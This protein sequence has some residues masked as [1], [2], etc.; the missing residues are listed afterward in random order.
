VYLFSIFIEGESTKCLKITKYSDKSQK[1]AAFFRNPY[2]ALPSTV[3][4]LRVD[5][6]SEFDNKEELKDNLER[7]AQEYLKSIKEAKANQSNLYI[8]RSEDMMSDPVGIIK[9]IALFF[10]LDIKDNVPITNDEVL[11]QIEN[12][13][14]KTEKTRVDKNGQAIIETL[15]SGHDGHMPRQKIAQRILL[16]NLIQEMDS[17]IITECYNEYMSIKPTNA[18]EGQRWGS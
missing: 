5:W 15:M 13:M 11:S 1:Q 14:S 6:G 8:G 3:V 18:K 16:D 9:D 2:D 4:K 12:E 17:E 7:C 10:G